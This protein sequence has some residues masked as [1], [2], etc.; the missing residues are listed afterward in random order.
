MPS[1]L[2]RLLRSRITAGLLV[3]LAWVVGAPRALADENVRF[4]RDILPLLSD[5]CFACHGPDEGKRKAGLRLDREEDA[6][7]T[8]KSGRAALVAG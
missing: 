5:H 4:S 2:H 7:R 3:G 8:L 6:F 1:P